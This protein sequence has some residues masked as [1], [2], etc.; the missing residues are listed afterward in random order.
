MDLVTLVVKSQLIKDGGFDENVETAV[1]IFSGAFYGLLS[2][3]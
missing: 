2:S 3:S 1:L